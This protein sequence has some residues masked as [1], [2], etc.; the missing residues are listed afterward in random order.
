MP[1]RNALLAAIGRAERSRIVSLGE[2]VH[3]GLKDVVYEIN[4]PLQHVYFPQ[5]GV[6]S[7]ITV[8]ENGTGVEVATVGNEGMVGLPAFL[9][10]RSIPGRAF[11]QVPGEALR[12]KATTFREQVRPD[13]ALHDLLHRYAQALFNQISWSVAC[14]RQHSIEQRCA[15]WLL[16]THD[17]VAGARFPLTQDFLAQ[18]LGVRR[19]SVSG[20]ASRLQRAGLI[21]YVRGVIT[22]RDRK[23]LEKKSCECY[24]I[25]REEYR[26][27]VGRATTR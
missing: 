11:A 10:A 8:L 7:L 24:R 17:R 20:V 6:L 1:E 14:L 27:L 3:L 23:G 21:R 18:M 4:R 26:R 19:A 15:R 12:L 25:V 2:V 22:I 16:M 13:D 9:G 5:S